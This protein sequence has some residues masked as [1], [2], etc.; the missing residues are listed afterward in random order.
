MKQILNLSCV[1]TN[2]FKPHSSRLGSSSQAGLS[3]LSLTYIKKGTYDPLRPK[4]SQN[5]VFHVFLKDK[6]LVFHLIFCKDFIKIKFYCN[7]PF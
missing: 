2:T 4:F 6:S 1:R 7:Y 5:L 3:G